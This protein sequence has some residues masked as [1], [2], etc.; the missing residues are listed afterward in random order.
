MEGLEKFLEA[1]KA[2]GLEGKDVMDFI[3]EERRLEREAKKE[4]LEAKREAEERQRQH[5]EN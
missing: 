5:E 2:M 4:E 1:A 3:R